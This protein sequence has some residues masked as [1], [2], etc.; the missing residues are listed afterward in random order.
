MA[1]KRKAITLKIQRK[2]RRVEGY[3]PEPS[4]RAGIQIPNKFKIVKQGD[5]EVRFLLHDDAEDENE[6]D[7]APNDRIIVFA[8]DR[9]LDELAANDT[10]MLDGTFKI[11]P[12]LIRQLYTI[13]VVVGNSGHVFPCVYAL[14]PDKNTATYKRLFEIL[15]SYRDLQ[16]RTCIMNFE[17]SAM[18]ALR[19]A[20]P[21]VSVEGCFFHLTQAVW[22]KVQA[23]GLVPQYRNNAA[24]R[25]AIKAL[26]V[27]AF[28]DT[29]QTVEVFEELQEE[30]E[31]LGEED[32]VQVYDYFEDTYIGR[33][34]RRHRKAPLFDKSIWNVK[35]RTEEG[36]P[37]TNNK[38]EAWHR[39]FQGMFDSPHPSIMRF[40]TAIQKEQNL[41]ASDLIKFKSGQ[42]VQKQEKRYKEMDG[43]IRTLLRRYREDIISKKDF[44]R[45]VGYNITLNV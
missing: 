43:R 16:P 15:K 10:W 2:R 30:A 17:L 24:V 28:F 31:G 12:V 7:E 39:T 42:E 37:R 35:R 33:V 18:K 6:N 19:D 20:F 45:G 1:P 5:E 21:G 11:S 25:E 3:A 27:L 13:H 23:C 32:L 38:L 34:G 40:F 8:T 4:T 36:I 26:C 9:M 14:L 29:S 44:I 22:R 41:Q